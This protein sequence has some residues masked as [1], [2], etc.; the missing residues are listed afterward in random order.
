[1]KNTKTATAKE[2]ALKLFLELD[3]IEEAQELIESGDYSVFTDEEA[4]EAAREYI[5]QSLWAFNA[6]F[7]AGHTRGGYSDDLVES[8]KALQKQCEGVNDAI[9]SMI[10]DLGHF[11]DEAISCDGR[12]HF[13]NSYDGEENE[14]HIDGETFYIYRNN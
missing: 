8:I 9:F 3:T 2:K 10:E 14:Q 11:V 6:D 4:D 13:M 5:L 1:M 7:I 12:G